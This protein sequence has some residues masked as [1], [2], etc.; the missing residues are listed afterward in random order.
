[1]RT[2]RVDIE[3]DSTIA[4]DESQDKQEAGEFVKVVGEFLDQATQLVAVA[5]EAM[6]LMGETLKFLARGIQSAGDRILV[7][8]RYHVHYRVL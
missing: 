4:L 8:S 6:P 7:R 1:M 5:P 2:Y 3:T